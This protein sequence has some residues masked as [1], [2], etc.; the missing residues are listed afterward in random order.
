MDIYPTAAEAVC[1]LQLDR[2]VT[3]FRP[4]AATRAARWF[5]GCFPSE[6]LCALKAH[7]LRAP[8]SLCG[9]PT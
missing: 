1:D 9:R 7:E 4:L 6:T 3:G 5:V 8:P 2:P